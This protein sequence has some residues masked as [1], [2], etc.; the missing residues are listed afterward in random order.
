MK[1]PICCICSK[2]FDNTKEG[3]IVFFKKTEY[4][5]EW[6]KEMEEQGKVEHPPY[7]EW[8]CG[9]HLDEALKLKHLPITEALKILKKKF[10]K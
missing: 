10:E 9:D 8:F 2:R 7:A 5:I 6:D 1:P 3:D 4:D